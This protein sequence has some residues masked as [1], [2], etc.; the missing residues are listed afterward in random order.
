[1]S[2]ESDFARIF[3]TWESGTKARGFTVY[4][5]IIAGQLEETFHRQ[6]ITK[7]HLL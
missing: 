6:N 3:L 2:T 7:G 1:M 5:W 4:W